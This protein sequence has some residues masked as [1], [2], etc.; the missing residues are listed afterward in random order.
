ML[1]ILLYKGIKNFNAINEAM[2]IDKL[3]AKAFQFDWNALPGKA[4]KLI[5][6][7]KVAK[8]DIP[9]AQVGISPP[10][11]VNCSELLFLKKKLHP[12]STMPAIYTRNITR[13]IIGSFIRIFIEK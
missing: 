3:K 6:L 2:G 4:R 7:T 8:M 10:P 1:F 12:N 11:E 5:L 13:S 9:T